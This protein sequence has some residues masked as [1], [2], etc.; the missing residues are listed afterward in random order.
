MKKLGFHGARI[1]VGEARWTK[2][3]WLGLLSFGT[4]MPEYLSIFVIEDPF[5]LK[6]LVI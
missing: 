5:Q 3:L 4:F 2:Y 1:I 6:L